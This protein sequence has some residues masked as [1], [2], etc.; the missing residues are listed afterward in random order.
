M[1]ERR[2]AEGWEIVKGY[3][4]LSTQQTAGPPVSQTRRK[5]AEGGIG[6]HSGAC[7]RPMPVAK[8]PGNWEELGR[9]VWDQ[10]AVKISQVGNDRECLKSACCRYGL[11]GTFSLKA[12]AA[13]L[14]VIVSDWKGLKSADDHAPHHL[15]LDLGHRA[16]LLAVVAPSSLRSAHLASLEVV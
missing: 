16:R 11:I 9:A 7:R 14:R 5:G 15:K 8:V 13:W 10:H 2:G 1:W 6:Q 3:L 12:P 4:W